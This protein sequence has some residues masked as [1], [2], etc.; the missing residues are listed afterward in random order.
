MYCRLH[1]DDDNLQEL[2][3]GQENHKVL[4]DDEEVMLFDFLKRKKQNFI[5]PLYARKLLN[6][7]YLKIILILMGTNIGII[8]MFLKIFL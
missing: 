7:Y 6:S 8:Q 3:Q 5:T 4:S 1:I 2:Q